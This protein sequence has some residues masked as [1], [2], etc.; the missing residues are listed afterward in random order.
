MELYPR[1]YCQIVTEV[2]IPT[3]LETGIVEL[4][5]QNGYLSPEALENVQNLTTD[6]ILRVINEEKLSQIFLFDKDFSDYLGGITYDENGRI[7]SAQAT[8]IQF[9]GKVDLDSITE[10][11]KKANNFGAPVGHI[12]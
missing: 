4:W 3:C 10:E 8:A 11:D 6:Q 9:Y 1:D 7:Q 5:A 2:T 12:F